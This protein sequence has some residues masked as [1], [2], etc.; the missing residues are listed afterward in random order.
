MFTSA[1][2]ILVAMVLCLRF[3][4]Y[5]CR[6]YLSQL[7]SR[8][9][10]WRS[11]IITGN[12]KTWSYKCNSRERQLQWKFSISSFLLWSFP[13]FNL[14][15]WITCICGSSCTWTTIDMTSLYCSFWQNLGEKVLTPCEAGKP[16]FWT[17]T[18]FFQLHKPYS[19]FWIQ[20]QK[21]RLYWAAAVLTKKTSGLW[22]RS[23][24]SSH[25]CASSKTGFG[26]SWNMSITRRET[27]MYPLKHGPAPKRIQTQT[28]RQDCH[29][30]H[31]S[32]PSNS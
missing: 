18:S 25:A 9:V 7:S 1:C 4:S 28:R 23:S 12:W 19:E 27:K 8:D 20:E 22:W 6:S 15:L 31:L 30:A 5:E 32:L 14:L 21:E 17:K 24:S 29:M 13:F 16:P 11:Q 3:Q 2:N 10:R 26:E